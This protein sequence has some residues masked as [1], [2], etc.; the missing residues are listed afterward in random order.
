MQHI[1]QTSQPQKL[2]LVSPDGDRLD[3]TFQLG[4]SGQ[5]ELDVNSGR[6]RQAVR[7][8]GDLVLGGEENEGYR[9]PRQARGQFAAVGVDPG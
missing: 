1:I 2:A 4:P 5:A 7:V 3:L 8:E 6:G 9:Q